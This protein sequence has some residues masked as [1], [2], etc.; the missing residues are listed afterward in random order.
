M[1]DLEFYCWWTVISAGLVRIGYLLDLW[2]NRRQRSTRYRRNNP[3]VAN[4]EALLRRRMDNDL[5][6]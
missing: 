2:S 6:R 3:G 4:V 1:S 5:S